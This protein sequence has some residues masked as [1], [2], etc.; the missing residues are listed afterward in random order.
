MYSKTENLMDLY[1]KFST[2]EW[3]FDNSNTR[4]LW[5]S[6]NPEERVMFKF[7][8]ETFDWSSYIKCYYYGIRKYILHEETDNIPIAL[9]K[10]RKYVF[11]IFH[12]INIEY[13]ILL[14]R[15]ERNYINM[16][17]YFFFFRLFWLHNFCIIVIVFVILQICWIFLSRLIH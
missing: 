1:H 8:L 4:K 17:L 12:Y 7:S 3:K 2:N 13:I 15:F 5:L 6:M 16:F 11:I 14:F 9:S 10:N